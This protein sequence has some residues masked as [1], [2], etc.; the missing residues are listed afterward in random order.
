[1]PIDNQAE[2]NALNA[3]GT[4]ARY[5]RLV[6]ECGRHLV[7]NKPISAAPR[8]LRVDKVIIE[9][10]RCFDSSTDDFFCNGIEGDT[11]VPAKVKNLLQVPCNGFALS[12]G[13]R[14]EI[15]LLRASGS[16]SQLRNDGFAPFEDLVF[17]PV[18]TRLYAQALH[19]EI[20]NVSYA[21]SDI[22]TTPENRLDL[23]DLVRTLDNHQLHTD[24]PCPAIFR[25]SYAKT[26]V[27]VFSL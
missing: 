26:C 4:E 16:L 23:L 3:T 20:P 24:A 12:V 25:E 5:T 9:L 2:S 15:N 10:P 7:A 8:F 21:C 14:C 11:C 6:R 22:P 17:E 13:V 1:L 18:G 19:R 27:G